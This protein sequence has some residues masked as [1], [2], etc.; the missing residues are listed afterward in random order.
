MIILGRV[1]KMVLFKGKPAN[2]LKKKAYVMFFWK[3]EILE[4]KQHYFEK[5]KGLEIRSGAELSST[6][7][8][9]C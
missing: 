2:G 6:T 5:I 3:S 4:E 8:T 7:L 1:G 9:V